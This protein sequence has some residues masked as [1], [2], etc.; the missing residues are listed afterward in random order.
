MA[1][2]CSIRISRVL[3][4][5]ALCVVAAGRTWAIEYKI[6]TAS[7]R[8]T[9]YAIGQDLAKLV[10][11]AAKIDLEVLATA[12]S[13]A[14]IR[15]LRFDPGVK[16]AIVQA[17]VY[18]AFIDRAVG[19]NAEAAG[20]IRPLRVILPLYN[21]EIHYVA[22]SDAPFNSLHEIKDARINGGLVGSGAAH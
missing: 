10:A 8:G 18:Q 17:D 5:A 12:G 6:V 20:I 11:P 22:R 19:G 14:N 4:A 9:Y 2:P 15:H 21:T 13:A 16:L 3:L 1:L 7:E